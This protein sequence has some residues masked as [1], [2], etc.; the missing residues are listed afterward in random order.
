[1]GIKTIE[2]DADVV[3]L[4][5][6]RIKNVFSNGLPVYL[7]ISGGKDSIV[8]AHLI[9]QS[10]QDGEVDPSLLTI[11]FIDEEA[12]F[13]DVIEIVKLWRKRFMLIGAKF[14]WFCVECTHFNC[15][16]LLTSDESFILWDRYKKDVWVREMP[17]YA[18]TKHPLLKSRQETYQSFLTNLNQDGI[19]M[20]GVRAA[21]SYQRMFNLSSMFTREGDS[22]PTGNT[23]VMPIYD[24]SDNDVWLYILN[25]N[26]EFPKTYLNLYQIGTPRNRLR[27]SQFFSID[28]AKVLVQLNEFE[29]DLMA[30]IIKREPNA[31]LAMLYWDTEMF[32]KSTRARRKVDNSVETK[33]YKKLL[34]DLFSDIPGNFH[35]KRARKVAKTYFDFYINMMHRFSDKTYRNF[36]E[37][38]VAG[39]P[40]LRRLRAF[41][42][43][44]K[45][46]EYQLLDKGDEIK[47][48]I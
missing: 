22:V 17:E 45:N 40:K 46:E 6:H 5:K 43:E 2:I 29:P 47:T 13:D 42:I 30:R 23:S 3:K 34:E 20:T 15:F 25:N 37:A 28:T 1:M 21:E 11:N 18:I 24:W 33:D 9:Y 19:T 10:I 38:L 12:M 48:W 16:N 32:G 7:S 35:G 26:L 44:I 39:D 41:Y 8:L 36:Y 31:N 27:I 14:N 4:A